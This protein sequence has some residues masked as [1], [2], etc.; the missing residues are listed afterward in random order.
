MDLQYVQSFW[1]I[2]PAFSTHW[3]IIVAL[4]VLDRREPFRSG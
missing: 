4:Q 2:A 1:A 3:M